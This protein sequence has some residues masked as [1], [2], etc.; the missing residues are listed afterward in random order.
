MTRWVA[1]LVRCCAIFL[2][3]HGY[4][5]IMDSFSAMQMLHQT[6]ALPK[7]MSE[8]MTHLAE[9]YSH[10]ISEQIYWQIGWCIFCDF[11]LAI[12]LWTRCRTFAQILTEG[13][14]E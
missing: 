6:G 7:W 14:D 4:L 5:A 10:E 3:W 2:G 11:T 12:V 8:A 13:L 1:L 9:K